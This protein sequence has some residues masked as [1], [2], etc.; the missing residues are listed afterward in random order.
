MRAV[1]FALLLLSL[2]PAFAADADKKSDAKK[3]APGNNVDMPFLMAP[4]T[5]VDGKLSGYAYITSLLVA[6]GPSD[7]L[8]VR[9]KLAI[10]QDAF[11][12][13]V[14]AASVAKSGEPD[15]VDIPATQARLLTDA[16]RIMGEARVKAVL[17]CS[18][19]LAELHPKQTPDLY[20]PPKSPLAPGEKGGK[21][22]KKSACD[23]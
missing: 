20:T 14:N 3:G 1:A 12:R 4:L 19:Q 23:A 10:V 18:I 2:A 13:D 11:V 7:A 15:K 5:E 17:V 22:G 6:S 8:A 9:D 21:N 16:R